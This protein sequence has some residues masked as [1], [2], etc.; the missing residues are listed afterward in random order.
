[1][2]NHLISRL[3]QAAHWILI[4]SSFYSPLFPACCASPKET[5]KWLWSDI[6]RIIH[7]SYCVQHLIIVP[8]AY[9]NLHVVN[10][11]FPWNTAV[12]QFII[13]KKWDF[14]LQ[15]SK[16]VSA[17]YQLKHGSNFPRMNNNGTQKFRWWIN[18]INNSTEH[19]FSSIYIC[20][21]KQNVLSC[22]AA[23]GSRSKTHTRARI[24]IFT[25]ITQ[26]PNRKIIK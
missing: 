3:L 8:I 6:P 4:C 12:A 18:I 19:Y 22:H 5:H 1:M 24:I 17:V 9:L 26:F 20:K 14:S 2:L 25:F 21:Q 10:L 13:N 7:S 11:K 15:Y 16:N 23:F